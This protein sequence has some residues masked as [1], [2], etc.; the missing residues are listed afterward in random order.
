VRV[1][2][3][4]FYDLEPFLAP[5]DTD[6]TVTTSQPSNDDILCGSIVQVDALATVTTEVCG[7]GRDGDA[8]GLP[9]PA[10]PD[11]PGSGVVPVVIPVGDEVCRDG[12][13]PACPPLSMSPVASPL[14]TVPGAAPGLKTVDERSGRPVVMKRQDLA[15]RGEHRTLPR[16]GIGGE[17]LIQA[18]GSLLLAGFVLLRSGNRRK[19]WPD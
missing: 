19:D 2:D 13:D 6:L 3:D 9:D 8:D 11:C 17:P 4:E 10:D 15:P 12:R 1:T 5:G 16:T 14:V 7:D 18:A